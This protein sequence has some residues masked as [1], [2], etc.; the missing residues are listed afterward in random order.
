MGVESNPVCTRLRSSGISTN[1]VEPGWYVTPDWSDGVDAATREGNGMRKSGVRDG[2]ANPSARGGMVDLSGVVSLVER[3]GMVNSGARVEGDKRDA[4]VG[5]EGLSARIGMEGLGASDGMEGLGT[6]IGIGGFIVRVKIDCTCLTDELDSFGA[7][8]V[9][10]GPV[11]GDAT[12]KRSGVSL[13]SEIVVGVD[14]AKF[15]GP[16]RA[17]S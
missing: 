5:I 2:A 4:R 15:L 6:S 14:P 17:Q 9:A 13:L 3:S 12:P 1:W 8:G 10:D 11:M 16:N 7:V